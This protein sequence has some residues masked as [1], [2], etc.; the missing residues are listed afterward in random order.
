MLLRQI[1]N[2]IFVFLAI[3][4]FVL[5]IIGLAIPV[6]PQVPFFVVSLFFAANGSKRFKN[7]FK[8]HKL[9]RKHLLPIVRRHKFLRE[10]FE[11]DETDGE[12]EI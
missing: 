5:G 7:W 4:F 9:Y 1:I 12:S 6:V 10:L 11:E 8:K 3:V 2:G